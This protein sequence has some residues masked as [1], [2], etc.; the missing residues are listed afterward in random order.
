ML[1]LHKATKYTFIF[2]LFWLL[3]EGALRRW[4]FP[5]ISSQLFLVKWVLC[6]F[7]YFIHYFLCGRLSLSFNYPYQLF[8]FFYAVWCVLT[9]F[10]TPYPNPAL[11]YVIGLFVHLIFIPVTGIVRYVVNSEDKFIRFLNILTYISIPLLILSIFQFYLPSDHILNKFVNEDQL[12][13]RT[14]LG[15]TRVTSVFTFVKL[16]NVYLLYVSTLLTSYIF[17]GIWKRKNVWL[18][19][20]VNLLA[21]I[22]TFMSGSRLAL[23]LTIINIF[24]ICF[25]VF[26]NY[27]SLRKAVSLGMILV[28]ILLLITYNTTNVVKNAIDSFFVRFERAGVK[29][30][31]E[32]GA[33]LDVFN[34][35]IDRVDV[36]KFAGTVGFQGWGTGTAYQGNASLLKNRF[37]YY[38]EEEA[39]RLA[40]E[41]GI[42]G[43]ILTILMRM[44]IFIH[45]L[46]IIYLIKNPFFKIIVYSLSIYQ[47]PHIF[48]LSNTIYNYM[49]NFI[50]WFNFGLILAISHFNSNGK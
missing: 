46:T 45:S 18:Y 2:L 10:L 44:F 3:T 50:Y 14:G 40:I 37:P 39:E 1:N 17:Y 11:V 31:T 15:F 41:L 30:K 47:I 32:G 27:Q 35:T 43:I 34:R 28:P 5:S 8:I 49:D 48:A 36:L 12:R 33:V 16:F 42:V 29:H 21:L 6:L 9:I 4:A 23:F 22:V 26:V 25:Y 24:L 38:Y 19:I 7:L 20:F 13:T